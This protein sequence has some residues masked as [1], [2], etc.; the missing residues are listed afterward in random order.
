VIVSMKRAGLLPLLLLAIVGCGP[1]EQGE[2]V[3]A[4]AVGCDAALTRCQ[5]EVDG[6]GVSLSLQPGLRPLKP[7]AISATIEDS[8]EIGLV[9]LDFQMI[10]MDMG[11]NRYRLLLQEG[12]WQGSA[13]LPVCTASRSDWL[14]IMEFKRGSRHYRVRFPFT[15]R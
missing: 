6:K 3:Q 7:F 2:V 9:L 4:E 15:S 1:N 12:Q 13:T 5:V 11:P 8:G 10:G 14:A